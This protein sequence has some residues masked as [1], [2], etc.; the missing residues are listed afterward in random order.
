MPKGKRKT[1]QLPLI[2]VRCLAQP[3]RIAALT[4][5]R[6]EAT[7]L[8][9]IRSTEGV[10]AH[11]IPHAGKLALV[12]PLLL[13]QIAPFFLGKDARELEQ[14]LWEVYRH[15]SNYK[16][17]GTALGVCLAAVEMALLELLCQ[18]AQCPLAALFGGARRRAI[19]IYVASSNRGNTPEEEL[20][21]LQQLVTQ[22]GAKAL[23]FRIGGRM[24]RGADSLPGR[25]ETLIPLVRE[26]FGAETVLYADANSSYGIEE[27]L[28][29]G[30][31]LEQYDYALFEEPCEFDDLWS[32]KVVADFLTI[33][34]GGGEQ[35][36]S[37]HR[38]RWLIENR[39][40]DVVQPDL[41]YG[42]GFLRALQVARLAESV[43]ICVTPHI[44][45]GGLGY[46]E[47]VHFA[48][49]AANIG[50]YIEF[51]GSTRLPLTCA[52]SSLQSEQGVVDCPTGVGLGIQLDPDFI[53]GAERL[54]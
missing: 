45:G 41:H 52:T 7:Y 39:A 3:V 18:S 10:V 17:Q 14:L 30:R 36:S 2:D 23:K 38:W 8:L 5:L 47:A 48:A 46:L 21:H 31:L 34:V 27:A 22:T 49:I 54:S 24:S 20:A 33:P 16:L 37:L 19:P 13:K 42:G 50:S 12:Y 28:R 6:R 43:G 53:A 11:T 29:I 1:V 4:L 32:T 40:L 44:S 26:S 15:Q 51:K 35:E 9:E 25:T